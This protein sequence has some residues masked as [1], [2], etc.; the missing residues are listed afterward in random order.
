MLKYPEKKDVGYLIGELKSLL[1]NKRYLIILDDVWGIDLWNQLKHALPDVKNRSRV[2]MTSRFVNVAQSANPKTKPYKLD[3]LGDKDSLNLLLQKAL[4]DQEPKN[5]NCPPDLFEV[6]GTLSKKCM[7]LPLALIVVGGILST[8]DQTY[9]AWERVLRTMDWHSEGQDCMK[10]LAMS[11]EDMPYYLK[12]CFL[13]LASFP[14][15]YEISAN[16]LIEMWIAEGFIPHQRRKTMEETA[17]DYL[18]ELF[19]RFSISW[20]FRRLYIRHIYTFSCKIGY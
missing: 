12:A 3:F 19:Q 14:E 2:L 5:E 1:K 20:L 4:P 16:R 11:Y 8:K 9:S 13:Y 6:A 7:G 18:E 15:D 10:V 17:E